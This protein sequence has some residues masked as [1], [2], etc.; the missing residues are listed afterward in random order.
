MTVVAIGLAAAVLLIWLLCLLNLAVA[1]QKV[2]GLPKTWGSIHTLFLP[3][4]LMTVNLLVYAIANGWYWLRGK[5]LPPP[6][7]PGGR[8][9]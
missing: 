5:P 7:K 6:P 4:L 9:R 2:Q 8:A 3:A 1:L